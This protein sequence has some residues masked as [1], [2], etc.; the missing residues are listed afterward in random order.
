MAGEIQR[1]WRPTVGDVVR[2]DFPAII[3]EWELDSASLLPLF[4]SHGKWAWYKKWEMA[5]LPRQDQLQEM[6]G[7]EWRYIFS[8]FMWWYADA[9]TRRLEMIGSI[10]QLW[11][12]FMMKEKF[13]KVWNGEEWKN[14][15]DTLSK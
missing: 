4:T 2:G 10:E 14:V 8:G 9:D 3:I 6:I 13:N 12:A 15:N 5:W 7:S 11:L 1:K